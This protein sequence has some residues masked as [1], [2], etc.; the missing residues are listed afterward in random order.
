MLR[1]C[2][3]SRSPIAGRENECCFLP[4]K[5]GSLG[6]ELDHRQGAAI[7]RE[8]SAIPSHECAYERHQRA[9]PSSEGACLE[10]QP[11]AATHFGNDASKLVDGAQ[12]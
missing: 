11:L 10:T 9:V 5:V 7:V 12:A 3:A 4:V 2:D 8:V 6:F 1:A